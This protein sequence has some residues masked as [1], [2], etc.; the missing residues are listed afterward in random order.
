MGIL[1]VSV[2]VRAPLCSRSRVRF[3]VGHKYKENIP[4]LAA[5]C[6]VHAILRLDVRSVDLSPADVLTPGSNRRLYVYVTRVV[7]A[8]VVVPLI[9]KWYICYKYLSPY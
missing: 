5:S 1:Y 8:H 6:V 9:A 3:P 4:F 7:T 2:K